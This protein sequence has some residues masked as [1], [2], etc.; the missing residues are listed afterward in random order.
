MKPCEAS[1]GSTSDPGVL[2]GSAV[3]GGPVE[4][5]ARSLTDAGAGAHVASWLDMAE[6]RV[7]MAGSR[8][9]RLRARAASVIGFP[10]RFID[11]TRRFRGGT[12][13]ATTTPFFLPAVAIATRW[14]HE[15]SVVALVYDMY[16]DALEAAGAAA[17]GGLV[18]ALATAMNRWWLRRVDGV[19]FIGEA[20]AEHVCRRYATP[21]AWTVIETGA[22]VREFAGAGGAPETDLER[23]CAGKRIIGYVG[24]FGHVHEWETLAEA[25]VRVLATRRDVGVVIAASGVAVPHLQRA[26][27][28]LPG[29]AV[30]FV[31]PLDDHA[32]AR[33]LARTDIAVA[34]LRD[35]AATTSMPSKTFSAMA[36]GSAIVAVAPAAS[37]LARLVRRHGCG[38]VV[39]PGD[40]DGLVHVF[41]RLL[42]APGELERC[43]RSAA[44][45]ARD[46][47]D[48]PKL[49]GRWR[50]FLERARREAV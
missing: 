32:W 35:A 5:L 13:V 37:D 25:V 33:L 48:M 12:V 16:P 23:W 49:A 6:W 41:T 36:A 26:W 22:D 34:T 44:A 8:A 29:E 2:I 4:R 45:A 1:F 38:E 9:D 3:G 50:E 7:Q 21:R 40:V 17:R 27:A 11:D 43:R 31:P 19:V 14:L 42:D 24:N 28:A 39:A 47:Y 30:R 46:V 10:I 18:D 15:G 20:M